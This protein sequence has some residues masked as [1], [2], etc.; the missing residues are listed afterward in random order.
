LIEPGE[1]RIERLPVTCD[2]KI[3]R[4]YVQHRRGGPTLAQGDDQSVARQKPARVPTAIEHRKFVLRSPQHQV[5]GVVERGR[6]RQSLEGS[7]HRGADRQIVI[8]VVEGDVLRFR[9]SR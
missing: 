7:D 1:R 2:R 6:G 4:H 8:G 5:N 3:A 9:G